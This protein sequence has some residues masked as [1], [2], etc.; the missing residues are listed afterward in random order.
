MV[1][2]LC[3]K[4]NTFKNLG[5][6]VIDEQ[7]KFGV[8]QRMNFAEKGGKECDVL[9]MSAT[10]IPRT[11]VLATYGDMD[12]SKLIEKP[13]DRLPI[14]TYSK[15]ENKITEIISYIKKQIK[16]GNQV[17]WVCPLIK[18]SKFLNYSS[19]KKKDMIG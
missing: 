6:V 13:K 3:F 14:I 1:H 19:V 15:P 10:P 2:T 16:L 4:K 5:F 9:L 12:I 11:M 7:H 18:E 8:K 17:F